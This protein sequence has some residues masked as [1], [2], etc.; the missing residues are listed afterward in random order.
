MTRMGSRIPNSSKFTTSLETFSTM[1]STDSLGRA[2]VQHVAIKTPGTKKEIALLRAWPNVQCSNVQPEWIYRSMGMG[3]WKTM[4]Q[5]WDHVWNFRIFR[6][7]SPNLLAKTVVHLRIFPGVQWPSG[8]PIFRR[9]IP[10]SADFLP[11][12]SLMLLRMAGFPVASDAA[13]SLHIV[14]M[15]Y[16]HGTSLTRQPKGSFMRGLTL[17]FKTNFGGLAPKT[18]ISGQTLVDRPEIW[19]VLKLV[20]LKISETPEHSP[21]LSSS[22]S[23]PPKIKCHFKRYP[24]CPDRPNPPGAMI[25]VYSGA[26]GSTKT[27]CSNRFSSKVF[28]V[29]TWNPRLNA[30]LLRVVSAA[31]KRYLRICQES[32]WDVG[33][34]EK[35]FFKR[36]LGA[37]ELWK[38]MML[39]TVQNSNSNVETLP[40]RMTAM[41][42]FPDVSAEIHTTNSTS[43]VENRWLNS[44]Q[45]IAERPA[46]DSLKLHQ[47]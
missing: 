5:S 7:T 6:E 27:P 18:I 47:V 1:S 20:S 28:T 35:A 9:S 19:D 33:M 23:L 24:P 13:G 25:K 40:G 16:L 2:R 46:V 34:V 44:P 38:I 17:P 21:V 15:C 41:L 31:C 12:A 30:M 11:Q 42:K 43:Y 45:K 37:Q 36:D 8:G 29:S 39:L 14:R 4:G 3:Q 10:L 26:Q 32:S 22:C